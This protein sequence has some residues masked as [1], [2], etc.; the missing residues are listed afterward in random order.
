MA[1][2]RALF[3]AVGDG[4]AP[5]P[6]LPPEK[7]QR[8][9]AGPAP[10][11]SSPELPLPSP[12]P[13]PKHF[14]AIVLVVLFLKRPKGRSTDR[15]P[16]SLSQIGRVVRDQICRFTNP[17]FSKLEKLLET[18]LERIEERIQDL[19]DKVDNI[20]RPSPNLLNDEQFTQEEN[21][22][23][24]S[25]EPA[26]LATAEGQSKTTSIQLRFLN[27]LKTPV[28]HD[29]EI[30]SESNT[31]IKVGIFNGDKM[32]ESGG[33]SNLQIEIFALEGDFPHASPKSWT[34]K[35]F[36]KHR[37]NSRDG[38]GNVLG[39][40]GTKAQLKKGQCDLG[41]IKFTEGSCKARS[42]KFIIGAR[43]CDGEVSGV[44]V[45]QAVMN[46]VVVQDRRNKSN[47]KNHP[48]KLN[49]SVHRLEE[50]AKVYAERLEKENIFTVE[51]F[52]KALNKDPRNL[53]KILRVNMEHKP[54]KK[55][56][57][58]ARECSLGGRHKLKLLF[59]TEKNVKLFF[60]CVHCLVGA[61]FFG[62]PYTLTDNFNFAQQELV[63]QLKKGA[64]AKLDKL[65]EDHVMTDNSPNPIHVDKYT[66]IGAGPSYMPSEQP[67][68]SVR[69]ASVHGTAAAERLSHDRIESSCPNAYN[70]PVP[71]SFIPD[72]PSMHN[73][74]GGCV[75]VLP[76]EGFSH[77][78]HHNELLSANANS[79][80]PGPSSS[81]A[82]HFLTYNYRDQGNL[83]S[84]QEQFS[85]FVNAAPCQNP[86]GGASN[87]SQF[88]SP[89]D[90]ELA[91][92]HEADINNYVTPGLD[93][94]EIIQSQ[95][96]LLSNGTLDG[97]TSGHINMA[98]P[99]QQPIIPGTPRSGQGSTQSQMQAPLAPTNDASVASASAQ[100]A[101]PPQQCYPWADH[102]E[103]W[104]GGPT[105]PI[106][107]EDQQCS[108]SLS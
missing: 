94:V 31:A 53:A 12:P 105:Q 103:Y 41:S 95:L 61:E 17:M 89:E 66:S 38:N 78:D 43:V 29:D 46:P 73:Y 83:L 48:P 96:F 22:E 45:Q 88:V 64:Y 63:D 100:Q 59:C 13:S 58:H 80:D 62:G 84:V 82:D 14:L 76:F 67:N 70:D 8:A 6:P 37:A 104:Y 108:P 75:P 50:I 42:G 7:R 91:F 5:P 81:T 26:G 98:L 16:I 30:K 11:R 77:D 20:T 9:G 107:S 23:G 71:S 25:A 52:L 54:W 69:L 101:L 56:T 18:K 34:P 40:E 28:Y 21:Q 72:H 99:P 49:D 74:Q 92:Q 55:M 32:I 87:M 44:Q 19:T 15:A 1:P 68:C 102:G 36:N 10:S 51:D 33:L 90:A 60:N 39:G 24:T 65:P 35:K 47:E 3:V 57:K 79:N 27:G 2:K 106:I 4:D 85:A 97:L 93:H 86:L